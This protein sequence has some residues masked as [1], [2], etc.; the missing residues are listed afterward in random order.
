MV[1]IS[2]DVP[3]HIAEYVRGKYFDDAAGIVRFPPQLD[4]YVLIYDLL[5]KWPEGVPVRPER[6]NLTFALPKRREGKSPETYCY[7]SKRAQHLICERLK[8]MMWAELHEGMDEAKHLHGIPF[9]ET[10][11]VF[12][13]RYGITSISE[14]ALLKNYQRWRDK[15]RRKSKRRYMRR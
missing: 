8:L 7:L 11:F 13:C 1:S 4:I 10:V 12:M 6:G 3:P 14:D 9:K 5:Q 15:L 2:F